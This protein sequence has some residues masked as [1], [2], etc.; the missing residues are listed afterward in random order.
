MA[1][2]LAIYRIEARGIQQ[3]EVPMKSHVANLTRSKMVGCKLLL[4]I[5]RT[6]TIMPS[7]T[8]RPENRAMNPSID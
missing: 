8:K 4:S 7:K 6:G 2:K 5:K 3:D 1:K